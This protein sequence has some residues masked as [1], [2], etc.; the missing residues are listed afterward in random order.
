MITKVHFKWLALATAVVSSCATPTSISVET[1]DG[2]LQ[3][4]ALGKARKFLGVPFAK[5]PIG[6]LRFMPPVQNAKWTAARDATV[7]APRCTQLLLDQSGMLQGSSEDC[8]YLNVYAPVG[9]KTP[10]AVMLYFPG[11]AYIIGGADEP[12]FEG[13]KLSQAGN[14]IVV[15]ANYRLGP[16]GF[17]NHP[18]LTGIDSTNTGNVALLDQREAMRWVQ[19]NIA[20]FG[21]DPNRVTIFGES[22][23]AGSVCM[24]LLSEASAPLFHRAIMESAPCTAYPLPTRAQAEAQGIAVS[25]ALGCKGAAADVASCLRG[26][27]EVEVL[28]ALPLNTNI[29]FGKGVAWGPVVDGTVITDQPAAL[30]KAGKSANVPIIVGANADE[31]SIFFAKAKNFETEADVRSA[32]GDLFTPAVVDAAVAHYGL[33]PSEKEVGEKMLGDVFFCDSRRVARAHAAFGRPAYRYYFARSFFDIVLGLGAFHGAEMPFIWDNSLEG[34]S[35]QPAGRGLKNAMQGYW[36][37]LARDGDPNGGDRPQWPAYAKSGDAVLRL[38]VPISTE[39][40][41]R[42]ENCDF[43]DGVLAK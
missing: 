43:W 8:L 17:M 36:S 19:R 2:T 15:T 20:S 1:S 40:L 21:G 11:G 13:T 18:S 28:T 3:G 4:T 10:L 35:V 25:D 29:I 31:G 33:S 9:T 6:E 30:F 27:S 5:P 32:L 7:A 34:L 37:G 16:F 22:A 14:V 39:T 24:H 12:I 38:D 26:K 41:L 23:G 42:T